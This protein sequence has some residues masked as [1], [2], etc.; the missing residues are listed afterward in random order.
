MPKNTLTLALDGEVAL[1]DFAKAINN[2][3][4][5]I[6]QLSVEVGKD[7]QINWIIEELYSGSAV[8]TFRGDY[9][10]YEVIEN[11][12]T[13]YED[14]GDALA[15]GREIPFS[16]LVQRHAKALTNVID[17]K[18]TAIRFET[19]TQDYLI[20]G[21]VKGES[22]E[23]IKF[24][25]GIVKGTVETLTKRRQL[26]FTLWD[27]LFDKPVHCYFKGGEEDN[28]RNVW[29][30]RAV[31]SGRIGRQT[32]TGKPLV[33]RDVK[34]VRPLEEVEPGSYSNARGS[35]PWGKGGETPEEMIRRL[36]DAT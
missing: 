23:P 14:V 9:S 24:S 11:V 2:F 3:N 13:A 30:K 4:L 31:V 12:I 32:G 5:L 22:S 15:S 36:R 17:H 29:G 20:S 8:A 7:A 10:D 18:I 27:S 26:S 28:M 1:Q 34:Y 25:Y 35:L 16:E 19:P 21:K 33:V 6:N